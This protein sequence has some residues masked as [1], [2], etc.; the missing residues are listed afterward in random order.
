ML[1]KIYGSRWSKIAVEFPGMSENDIKNKFYSSLKSI[2]N[3]L[4]GQQSLLKHKNELIRFVDIAI[5]YDNLLPCNG[6]SSS[7]RGGIRGSK[8][9]KGMIGDLE[10]EVEKREGV[11]SKEARVSIWPVSKISEVNV[12]SDAISHMVWEQTKPDH[13]DTCSR[14]VKTLE[15]L[16]RDEIK[17]NP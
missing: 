3:R 2:A 1:F 8:R 7:K 9:R 6:K 4:E 16:S 17:S 12:F 10:E 5:I 14:A 15:S 13:A 11:R